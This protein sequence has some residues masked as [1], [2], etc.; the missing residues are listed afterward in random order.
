MKILLDTNALL[1]IIENNANLTQRVRK[2]VAD[3]THSIFISVV[4]LWEIAIKMSI[5]K[6]E[7]AHTLD[8]IIEKIGDHNAVILPIGLDAIR[9][10]RTLSF[11]HRDPFDRLIIAQAQAQNLTIITSDAVFKSYEVKVLW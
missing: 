9:K 2:I 4:S 6:L 11:H 8:E 1:W 7:L 3:D 10:I 5:G